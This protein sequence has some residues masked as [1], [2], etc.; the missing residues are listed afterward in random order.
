MLAIGVV[1]KQQHAAYHH[2]KRED[3]PLAVPYK[4]AYELAHNPSEGRMLADEERETVNV[5]KCYARTLC[6][7]EQG[8]VGHMELDADFVDETLVETAQ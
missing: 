8:V 2:V 7:A 5:L 1:L 6:H 4:K 3:K